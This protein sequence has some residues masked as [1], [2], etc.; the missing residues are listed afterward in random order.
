[1]KEKK[2]A[3]E[4]EIQRGSE[5]RR[6]GGKIK[7]RVGKGRG[8]REGGFYEG[9]ERERGREKEEKGKRKK[10]KETTGKMKNKE[11]DKVRKKEDEKE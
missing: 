8:R 10:S 1:M 9:E 5:R 2:E 7:G 11:L 3:K 4:S 6:N